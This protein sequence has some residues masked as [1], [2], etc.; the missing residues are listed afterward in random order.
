[1]RAPGW[2]KTTPAQDESLSWRG[3]RHDRPRSAASGGRFRARAARP[4]GVLADYYSR[5]F[6]DPRV[7]AFARP[8]ARLRAARVQSQRPGSLAIGLFAAGNHSVF[9]V[10]H[11]E[12]PAALHVGV[13]VLH[14]SENRRRPQPQAGSP[15]LD[16]DG[17]RTPA[18]RRHGDVEV[19]VI[20]DRP[21]VDRDD[22]VAGPNAGARGG[23]VSA[24]TSSTN[25]PEARDCRCGAG[26]SMDLPAERAGPAG[27]TPALS[28]NAAA[29]ANRILFMAI[30]ACEGSA[31]RP[32]IRRSAG[33]AL[34][35]R[36]SQTP[37]GTPGSRLGRSNKAG[38]RVCGGE[39]P[40][41]PRAI[42]LIAAPMF[43]SLS[44]AGR[45]P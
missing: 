30:S 9:G 27:A 44:L 26:A 23:G 3:D 38:A 7:R 28:A 2:R 25:A 45:R 15:A 37:Y 32:S 43:P 42:P 39:P 34:A 4:V 29:P 40:C 10:R 11:P 8:A 6:K 21:A 14:E 33:D 36:R 12:H 5:G 17:E 18:A 24:T 41:A 16:V 35:L 19:G 1:M 31:S 22:D 20:G 13:G